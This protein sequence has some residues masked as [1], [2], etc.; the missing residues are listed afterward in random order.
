MLRCGVALSIVSAGQGV[1]A[2]RQ[3]LGT[4]APDWYERLRLAIP[5]GLDKVLEE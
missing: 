1:P 2:S 5:V 3:K 4:L